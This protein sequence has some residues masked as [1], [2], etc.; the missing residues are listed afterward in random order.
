[1]VRFE[2]NVDL[3]VFTD[4]DKRKLVRSKEKSLHSNLIV[5]QMGRY[6]TGNFDFYIETLQAQESIS[7]AD[8]EAL[9]DLVKHDAGVPIPLFPKKAV[10][11]KCQD[12]PYEYFI[13]TNVRV[14][15]PVLKMM[16]NLLTTKTEI[17][18]LDKSGKLVSTFV[19][20]QKLD[21]PIRSRDF[22][23]K[24]DKLYRAHYDQLY[25]K[26]QPYIQT[27]IKEAVSQLTVL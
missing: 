3:D 21:K 19:S 27:S 7:V 24:F 13:I 16:G 9:V 14:S 26:L 17:K 6:R 4:L 20:E 22:K 10:V 18:I 11:K 23:G 12:T 15:K 2:V 1:M 5:D 8:R 25:E